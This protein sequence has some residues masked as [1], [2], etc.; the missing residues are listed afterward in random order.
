MFPIVEYP[1]VSDV[2]VYYVTRVVGAVIYTD[3]D[4]AWFNTPR[5]A[6]WVQENNLPSQYLDMMRG[7]LQKSWGCRIP[8]EMCIELPR[9]E[10]EKIERWLA[11]WREDTFRREYT[12]ALRE[13]PEFLPN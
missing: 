8:T 2:I 9:K 7:S 12:M 5:F 4:L 10:E 1:A 6:R 13:H 11:S 3:T